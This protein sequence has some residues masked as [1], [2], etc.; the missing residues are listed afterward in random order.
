MTDEERAALADAL[1]GSTVVVNPAPQAFS[2]VEITKN[3]KGHVWSIKVYV[4][5]GREDEALARAKSIDHALTIEYGEG[6]P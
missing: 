5:A 3:S 6:Q 2:S 1:P 4:P